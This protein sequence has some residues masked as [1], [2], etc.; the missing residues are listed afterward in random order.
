MSLTQWVLRAI[1]DKIEA[2]RMMRTL[3]PYAQKVDEARLDEILARVPDV[4]P[5]P[6]DEL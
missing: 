3:L 5:I 2:E 6:G 4:D 1:A